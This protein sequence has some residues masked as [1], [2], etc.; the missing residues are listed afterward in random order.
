MF[1]KYLEKITIIIFFCCA[2][3]IV[4]SHMLRAQAG[5]QG[6][7]SQVIKWLSVNALR[8]WF[9]NFGDEGEYFRRDRTTYISNDQID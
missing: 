5:I 8:S 9:N 3:T 7:Q 4:D 2:F 1:R 6:T